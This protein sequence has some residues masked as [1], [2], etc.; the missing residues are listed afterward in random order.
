MQTLP[1]AAPAT[2]LVTAL[3]C[4]LGAQLIETHISWVL[5]AADI[6]YKIKKPLHLPFV[7]YS[8]LP[9]RLH[10][11]NEDGDDDDSS[12]GGDGGSPT[13]GVGDNDDDELAQSNND[14]DP[15]VDGNDDDDAASDGYQDDDE[16]ASEGVAYAIEAPLEEVASEGVADA[17]E[18][19]TEGVAQHVPQG[20]APEGVAGTLADAMDKKY[21]VQQRSG[22]RGRKLRGD[23]FALRTS[24]DFGGAAFVRGATAFVRGA[25]FA[26]FHLCKVSEIDAHEVSEIDTHST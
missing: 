25:T 12:D 14:D 26:K 5:L 21:G 22:V 9:A 18:A 24:V 2:T 6:A 19:T 4:E 20:P 15:P 8:T 13:A 16:V 23:G 3:A 1:S 11:C 7:D 17:T 10:Y